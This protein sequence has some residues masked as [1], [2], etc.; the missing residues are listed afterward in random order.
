MTIQLVWEDY[1][2]VDGLSYRRQ[3]NHLLLFRDCE[4]L[5]VCRANGVLAQLAQRDPGMLERL[6]GAFDLPRCEE[7]S[8]PLVGQLGEA[9]GP[10]ALDL[11]GAPS[12]F[13]RMVVL[14]RKRPPPVR[15][16]PEVQPALEPRSLAEIAASVCLM[17]L[18]E[19]GNPVANAGYELIAPDGAQRSGSF[20][21]SGE[22]RQDG[23]KP[24]S[25]E[26]RPSELRDDEVRIRAAPP[27]GWL[28]NQVSVRVRE[29]SGDPL[30]QLHF[31]VAFDDGS[32]RTGTLDAIGQG[33]LEGTPSCPL[34]VSFPEFDVE[35]WS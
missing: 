9:L 5:P 32:S 7:S 25:Y 8:F 27:D 14:E 23:I 13:A 3:S 31:E 29:A 24:G 6:R 35:D 15:P 10:P 1:V 2:F 22:A 19:W 16:Q 4:P 26:L 12:R 28:R 17:L 20:A 11:F 18:D 34:R 21:T 33:R 30:S